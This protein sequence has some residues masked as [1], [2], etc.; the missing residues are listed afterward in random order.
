M[1]CNKRDYLCMS[2]NFVLNTEAITDSLLFFIRKYVSYT[3][4]QLSQF[5]WKLPQ[6]FSNISIEF[7]EKLL[8]YKG[9]CAIINDKDKGYMICDFNVVENSTNTWGIPTSIDAIDVFDHNKIIGRYTNRYDNKKKKEKIEFV[10]ITDNPCWY[11]MNL[12][13][14]S[15]CNE[16]SNIREAVDINTNGQKFPIVLQGTKEQ[17]LALQNIAQDIE[18][19]NKYIFLNKDYD[20]DLISSIDVASKFIA[21]ELLDVADRTENDLQTIVGINNNNVNKQSGVSSDEVNANNSL[22]DMNL[23]T[24]LMSRQKAVEKI[25]EAFGLDVDVY[26]NKEYKARESVNYEPVLD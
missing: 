14:W 11:P 4:I 24:R 19:G 23:S 22:I 5:G 1:I 16:L 20:K 12:S 2:K 21:K 18:R 25:K 15:Y 7:L 6:E 8:Y 26:I 13:V 17:K 9:K 10:I 3:S